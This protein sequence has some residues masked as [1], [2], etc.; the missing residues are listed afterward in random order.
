MAEEPCCVSSEDLGL[1]PVLGP[2][3]NQRSLLCVLG[4][5]TSNA[6]GQAI[7]SW[8]GYAALEVPKLRLATSNPGGQAIGSWVRYLGSGTQTEA[9]D[10]QSG[11]TG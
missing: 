4:L 10:E 6:R 1:I 2:K 7:G 3:D 8:A 5:A 9:D 11:R